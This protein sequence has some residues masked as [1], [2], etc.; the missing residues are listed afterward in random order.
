[1]LS[2]KTDRNLD[3][4]L[5]FICRTKSDLISFLCKGIAIS[6][7][8]AVLG[9]KLMN[10]WNSLS[11]HIRESNSIAAFKRNVLKFIEGN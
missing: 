4:S 10:E 9:S 3:I 11:N 8:F 5:N 6:I 1:M 7:P 2:V